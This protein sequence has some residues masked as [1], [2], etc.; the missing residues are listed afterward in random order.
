M[1]ISIVQASPTDAADILALQKAAYQSEAMLNNDWTIP[2]LTQTLS[3]IETEFETKA[4]LKA[5]SEKRIIGS[6]RAY[7]D[8]GTCLIGRLIVHPDY[9]G[10]GIGTSLMEKLETVFSSAERFELFTGTKSIDNIRF[11]QRLGYHEY[12]EENLS[13]KVR[14]VFMEKHQKGRQSGKGE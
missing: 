8:S 1:N 12:R 4:F 7:L 6:A 3:E 2:P 10:Q 13:S 14:L 11:Y 9:Q 5:V